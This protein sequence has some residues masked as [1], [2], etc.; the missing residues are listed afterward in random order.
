MIT[1]ENYIKKT[2][3][4][5]EEIRQNYLKDINLLEKHALAI[6]E[7]KDAYII[8]DIMSEYRI[9]EKYSSFMCKEAW[10]FQ[11]MDKIVNINNCI[12]YLQGNTTNMNDILSSQYE[13]IKLQFDRTYEFKG[14]RKYKTN[15]YDSYNYIFKAKEKAIE[16]AK[17][18]D[19]PLTLNDLT[20]WTKQEF[21]V[22]NLKFKI[23]K[24]HNIDIIIL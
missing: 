13:F 20:D 17:L 8:K 16:F 5:F 19:I 7:L 11:Y 1:K 14:N 22:K 18:M 4:K 21:S 2:L 15:A 12:E 23:Y 6:K 24:N 3:E 9:K 10:I